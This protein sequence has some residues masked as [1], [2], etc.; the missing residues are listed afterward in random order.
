MVGSTPF[1]IIPPKMPGSY[2]RS[3]SGFCEGQMIAI[4][5]KILVL[6][7]LTAV[8]ARL[9]G[10]AEEEQNRVLSYQKGTYLGKTDQQLSDEQL[11]TLINRSNAQRVY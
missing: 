3:A 10:C 9:S 6:F 1:L 4:T 2:M 11:R 5:R 7:A 8:V